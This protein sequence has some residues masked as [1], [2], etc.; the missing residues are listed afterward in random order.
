[1]THS[2]IL[3]APG[4]LGYTRAMPDSTRIRLRFLTGRITS[5]RSLPVIL[6]LTA[7]VS[8]GCATTDTM[9][10]PDV[11]LVDLDFVDATIF[12]STLDVGVRIFNENPEPLILDGAVIKLEL[13]GRNFGKGASSERTEIPRLDSVVLRL[14][15]HLSHMAV[16]TRLK[17]V[18]E[19]K[20]V[21]YSITGKV[22]VITPSGRVKRLPIDKQGQIDLRGNAAQDLVDDPTTDG[23]GDG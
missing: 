12:E 9:A 10:P 2:T 7:V 14:E 15:M 17:T 8:F 1:M 22:Y 11:T 21:N 3:C 5:V 13:E 19:S 18:V 4:V 23:A 16:A 6:A 20:M